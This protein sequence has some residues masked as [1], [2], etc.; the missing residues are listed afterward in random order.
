MAKATGK[1]STPARRRSR[2]GEVI[3]IKEGI[4]LRGDSGM[5]AVPKIFPPPK[6]RLHDARG[7]PSSKDLIRQEARRRLA[8][9]DGPKLLSTFSRKLSTWLRETYPDF[10]QMKPRSVE[11]VVRALWQQRQKSI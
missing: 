11:N 8:A 1:V 9:G 3:K 10:L 7:R 6:E 2:A 5:R 4:R